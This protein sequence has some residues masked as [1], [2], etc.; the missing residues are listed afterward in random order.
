MAAVGEAEAVN[1]IRKPVRKSADG[2]ASAAENGIFSTSQ[3]TP[4]QPQANGLQVYFND[5]L[6]DVNLA[7]SVVPSP[8]TAAIIA[9]LMPAAIRPYS[10]AVAPDSSAQNFAKDF[11]TVPPRAISEPSGFYVQTVECRC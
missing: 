7:L 5:V 4:K 2:P 10:I 8:L 11:F 9:R 3:P 6:I 1:Q